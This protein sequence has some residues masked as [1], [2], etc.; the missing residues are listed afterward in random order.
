MPTEPVETFHEKL[1]C[2]EC[3]QGQLELASAEA[4]RCLNCGKVYPVANGVPLLFTDETMQIFAPIDEQ[5]RQTGKA[6]RE[7]WAGSAYHWREY[8]IEA[9]LP[10]ASTA[11]EVLL[12]GCG[13][14]GERDYL[15]HLGYEP[16]AFDVI[17]SS[18]TDFL[19][20]AHRLPL[21]NAAFDIVLSMQV[22]E[23]LHSPWLAAQEIARVIKPGGWFVGSLAFLKPFHKSYYHMSHWALTKLL[24][25]VGL[26]VDKLEG[27]QSLTYTF[28]GA[29]LPLG[30]RRFSRFVY[31]GFDK[32]LHGLRSR[33]W[34]LRTGLNS[35]QALTDR[36]PVDFPVSF[37]TFERLRFAPA[38]V[39]RARKESGEHGS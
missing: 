2:P 32:L 35:N 29:L 25:D 23:H 13:D 34:S 18:G 21:Q 4:L 26:V 7:S 33:L 14:G 19:A 22:L 37:N 39:F 5:R 1:R 15:V 31:G 20:D 6:K 30:P 24:K 38:I 36:Y 27:A 11:K 3:Q 8:N 9:F 17:R 28:Y 10:P 16:L 12:L